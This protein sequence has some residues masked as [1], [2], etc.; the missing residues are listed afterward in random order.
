[1]EGFNWPLLF[2]LLT[3]LAIGLVGVIAKYRDERKHRSR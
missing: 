2:G 1:M 3:I